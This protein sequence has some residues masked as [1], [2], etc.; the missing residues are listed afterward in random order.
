MGALSA[1]VWTAGAWFMLLLVPVYILAQQAALNEPLRERA[2]TDEKT[3]LLRFESWRSLAVAE[4]QH[5]E[6]KLRSWSVA[7]ADLDHF[8]LYNDEFGHLAGDAALAAVADV[9]REQLRSRDVVGR[10]GGEEFCVL[11]PDTSAAEA[12]AI[13]ERLCRAVER[14][15]RCPAASVAR[16]SASAS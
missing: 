11:L 5:C 15:A 10:F 12:L 16:R 1:A 6:A 9:L 14:R 2:E 3:G 8:K 4:Q 13:A 7:F